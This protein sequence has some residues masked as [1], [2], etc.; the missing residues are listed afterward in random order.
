VV[1]SGEREGQRG[2]LE[3]G[4]KEDYYGII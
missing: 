4:V 3:V 2:N 1:S